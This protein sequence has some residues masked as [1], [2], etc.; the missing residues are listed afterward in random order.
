MPSLHVELHFSPDEMIAYY[1]GL[2]RAVHA[3]AAEG[4][5][6]NFPATALQ[7]HVTSDGVQGWF[8]LDFDDNHK[9]IRLERVEG[10]PGVNH[11]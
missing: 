10:P 2:A 1:R 11:L 4:R 5:T 8:R 6:V 3:T 9:F 7:R